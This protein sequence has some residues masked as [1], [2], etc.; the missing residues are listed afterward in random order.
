[1]VKE[2]LGDSKQRVV[3]NGKSSDW[4]NILSRVVHGSVLGLVLFLCFIHDFDM[5]VEMVMGDGKDAK[6]TILKK[7][8]DDTGNMKTDSGR[9]G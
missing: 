2:W 8:A 7:F 5:A 9:L 3:L 1:M 4:A 6:A